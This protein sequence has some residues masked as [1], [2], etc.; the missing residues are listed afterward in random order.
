MTDSDRRW[1]TSKIAALE[2]PHLEAI[3]AQA[4]YSDSA[5]AE[6]IV[7]TLLERREKILDLAAPH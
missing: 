6:Y 1:M 5:N 7:N 4:Q 3:V 2:R